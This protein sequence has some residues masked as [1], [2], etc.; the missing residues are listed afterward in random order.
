MQ[1]V[2]LILFLIAFIGLSVL[3]A[4]TGFLTNYVKKI[5]QKEKSSSFVLYA[6]IENKVLSKN[7][8]K[9][10]IILKDVVP[11]LVES[12]VIDPRKF[13]NF[14]FLNQ[15]ADQPITIN[16]DNAGLFLNFLWAVG[17]SNKTKFNEKSPLNTEDL[18]N[19]ASTAGWTLGKE[20]NGAVYF[21]KYEIVRLT[22]QQEELVLEVAKNTFRPCCGNSTF[23]QD[24]NHGSALLGLLELGASQGLS[25]NELYQVALNFNSFWFP[26]SYI[27]T[28]LYF[29]MTENQ[30]WETMDPKIIL[31]ADYSSGRGWDK[32]VGTLIKKFSHLIPEQK[33]GLGC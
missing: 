14:E 10:S 7:G 32:N 33:Q 24:C 25:K 1:K 31:S 21:N 26:D 13:K 8:Y 15:F 3:N 19:F 9:T 12:G 23:F 20:K 29:K 28:A 11:K 6:E 2:F 17:L 4:K 22:K 30:D 16:L 5:Q 27:K 18:P